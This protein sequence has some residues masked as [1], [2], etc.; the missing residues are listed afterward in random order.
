MGSCVI[1]DYPRLEPPRIDIAE[2]LPQAF[3]VALQVGGAATAAFVRDRDGTELLFYP[4]QC[5]RNVVAATLGGF[6]CRTVPTAQS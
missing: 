2:R 3:S 4:I 6:Q 5:Q 1:P